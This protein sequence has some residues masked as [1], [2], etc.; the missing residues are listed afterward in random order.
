MTMKTVRCPV[1]GSNVVRVSD[2]EGVVLHVM[3]REFESSTGLC[4]L[5]RDALSGGLL[6]QLVERVA[7]DTLAERGARCVV[8]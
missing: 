8:R 2:M 4:R 6:S 5:R 3:C 7:E 1:L